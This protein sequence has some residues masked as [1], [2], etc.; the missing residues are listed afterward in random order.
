[1]GG[2]MKCMTMDIPHYRTDGH[3]K[4]M[5]CHDGSDASNQA[6]TTTR[7]ALLGPEDHL[8]VAQAWSKE[9]EEYLKFNLKRDYVKQQI[10]EKHIYL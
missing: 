5:V 10:T 6:L 8:Y 2:A 9:K 4:V 3:L 1:M 7:D